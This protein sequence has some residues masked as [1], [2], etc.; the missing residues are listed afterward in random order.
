MKSFSDNMCARIAS[1][2]QLAVKHHM[3]CVDQIL[4]SIHSIPYHYSAT[5]QYAAIDHGK[6]PLGTDSWCKYQASVP[7][8]VSPPKHPNYLGPDAVNLVL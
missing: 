8:G 7:R 5:D 3:G 6:C 1:M 2:Y 4:Q